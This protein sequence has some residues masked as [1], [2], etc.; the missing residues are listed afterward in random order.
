MV[1]WVVEDVK[2][3][4]V[5]GITLHL[6]QTM[7]CTNELQVED[8]WVVWDGTSQMATAISKTKFPSYTDAVAHHLG[9]MVLEANYKLVSSKDGPV[10]L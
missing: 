1:P 3:L 9:R 10:A 6:Y 2:E 7:V 4:N 5:K 8:F